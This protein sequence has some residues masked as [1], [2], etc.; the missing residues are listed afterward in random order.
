M[1]IAV[2][3]PQVGVPAA[4]PT[5]Y[6]HNNQTCHTILHCGPTPSCTFLRLVGGVEG[7]IAIALLTFVEI[8]MI[9]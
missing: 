8:K 5:S 4:L 7:A 6:A 2:V 3:R 1:A 9:L